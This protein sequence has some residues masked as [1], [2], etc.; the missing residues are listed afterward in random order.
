MF[1]SHDKVEKKEKKGRERRK[2]ERKGGEEEEK[3]EEKGRE[4]GRGRKFFLKCIGEPHESTK[5]KIDPYQWV[6][7]SCKARI[8]TDIYEGKTRN[9]IKYFITD[10][11]NLSNEKLPWE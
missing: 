10:L 8:G 6:G 4:R 2:K 11:P 7:K 3:E 1:P 5:L 9:K